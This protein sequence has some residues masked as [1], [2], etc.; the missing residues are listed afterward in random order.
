MLPPSVWLPDLMG[1][2]CDRGE[3][4]GVVGS[5]KKGGLSEARPSR[6]KQAAERCTTTLLRIPASTVSLF[7][8]KGGF[9]R[10]HNNNPRIDYSSRLRGLTCQPWPPPHLVTSRLLQN[11]LPP[12][13]SHLQCLVFF[14]TEVASFSFQI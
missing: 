11:R 10:V 3:A 6:A 1:T 7:Q 12:L 14:L 9:C 5:R 8:V 2:V 4:E 13:C